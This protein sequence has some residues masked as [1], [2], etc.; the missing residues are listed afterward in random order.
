MSRWIPETEMKKCPFCGGE[1]YR[2]RSAGA[3]CCHKCGCIG[4]Y[5][6]DEKDAIKKWNER[7]L[8]KLQ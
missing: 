1:P 4:P 3:V 5:G 6:E 7:A 8:E 2:D